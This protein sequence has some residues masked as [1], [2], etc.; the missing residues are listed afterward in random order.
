MYLSDEGSEPNDVIN[1]VSE[2]TNKDIALSMDLASVDL[3]E[4]SHHD[5]RVENHGKMNRRGC[6][7]V[8][9]FPIIEVENDVTCRS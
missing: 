5:E 3:V 1:R 6:G 4:Q 7:Q 9:I 8:G 2:E